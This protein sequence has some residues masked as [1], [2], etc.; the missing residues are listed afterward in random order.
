MC[1]T[2]V[3]SKE[4]TLFLLDSGVHRCQYGI[5]NTSRTCFYLSLELLVLAAESPPW[6]VPVSGAMYC[7]STTR[8]IGP[9]RSTH[10]SWLNWGGFERLDPV[11]IFLRY[12]RSEIVNGLIREGDRFM[13]GVTRDGWPARYPFILSEWNARAILFKYSETRTE[14]QQH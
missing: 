6:L 5:G 7:Q 4:V 12:D 2:A 1:L 11:T 10:I 14:R 9:A 3:T 13:S 8:R